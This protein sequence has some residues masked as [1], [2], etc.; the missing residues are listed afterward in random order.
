VRKQDLPYETK[1]DFAA[2][3]HSPYT[4]LINDVLKEDNYYMY[5]SGTCESARIS[6]ES[7]D[8]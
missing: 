5:I 6:V 8:V 4:V 3:K 2:A 1:R 7:K